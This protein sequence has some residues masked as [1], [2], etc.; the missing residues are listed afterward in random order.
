MK[1]FNGLTPAQSE[2]LAMLAEEAAEVIQIVGKI[3][4]HGY[5]SHH[6]DDPDTSN[7]QLLANEIADLSAVIDLMSDD[8]QQVEPVDLDEIILRKLR[9]THHQL[10]P[11]RT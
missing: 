10:P 11:E 1:H 3:L 8:W 5:E 6:P 9:F 7:R 4:R 2:R